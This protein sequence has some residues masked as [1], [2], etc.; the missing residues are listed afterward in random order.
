HQRFFIERISNGQRF[1]CAQQ[2]LAH[3]VGNRLVHDDAPLEVQRWPAVPTAPKKIDCVAISRS[4][5]GQ[6]ISALLPPNSMIV[7]PS[8]PWTVL[9]TFKPIATEPVAE[10]NGIRASSANFWPTAFRSPIS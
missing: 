5:V 6:T 4:A 2:F 9:A 8:R 10:I 1:V 7:L 3:F